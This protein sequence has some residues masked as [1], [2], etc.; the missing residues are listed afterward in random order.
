MK[1]IIALLVL[2]FAFSVNATAQN[3]DVTAERNA[4][5]DV[6]AM[7]EIITLDSNMQD[8]FFKLF[9]K[10]HRDMTAAGVTE[11]QKKEI[12][13]IVEAKIRATLDGEQTIALE[14]NKVVFTQLISGMPSTEIKE[15]KVTK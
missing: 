13:A 7:M 8:A 14:K 10:K 9:A 3:N 2:F 6:K 5:A 15:K 4:K 12:S 1:K 11:M